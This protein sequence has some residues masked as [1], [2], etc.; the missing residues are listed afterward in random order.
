MS[1]VLAHDS[2][3]RFNGHNLSSVSPRELKYDYLESDHSES[4]EVK[5]C[6]NQKFGQP[7]LENYNKLL[8]VFQE[9]GLKDSWVPTNQETKS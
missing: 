8:P 5:F 4:K 9:N 1:M 6:Q 2:S 3:M 7:L